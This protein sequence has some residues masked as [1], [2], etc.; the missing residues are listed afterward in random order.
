MKKIVCAV[1][2]FLLV[3]VPSA[4]AGAGKTASAEIQSCTDAEVTGKATLREHASAEGVKLVDIDLSVKGLPAGKHAVHIHEVG[5]CT[6]CGAAKGHFDPGPNSN[7]NPD[8]NHPFH[9]GDLQ[10]IEVN[11]AGNGR[12][13]PVVD[14]VLPLEEVQQAHRLLADRAQFGKVLLEP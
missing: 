2:L 10:N 6:P 12:L 4:T 5:T 11:A 8:G 7:S 14:R 1:L 3:A 13:K 9:M